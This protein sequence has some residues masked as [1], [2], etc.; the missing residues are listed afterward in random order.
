MHSHPG[1]P[2][3]SRYHRRR[4]ELQ[5]IIL[6]WD[7]LGIRGVAAQEYDPLVDLM[8]RSLSEGQ[9]DAVSIESVFRRGVLGMARAGYSAN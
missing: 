6:E 4:D 2:A 9:A 3:R 8:L 5:K 7:P 1:Q